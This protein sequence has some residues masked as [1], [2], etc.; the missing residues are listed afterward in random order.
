M[1]SGT[2]SWEMGMTAYQM[3]KVWGKF[4]PQFDAPFNYEVEE[5]IVKFGD[6]KSNRIFDQAQEPMEGLVNGLMHPDP[7][8][9]T[10]MFDL[11]NNKTFFETPGF[12]SPEVRELMKALATGDDAKIQQYSQ[13]VDNLKPKDDGERRAKMFNE[14]KG[15]V[16]TEAL[17]TTG[18]V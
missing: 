2:D 12:G 9:R 3:L 18:L 6:D 5:N 15:V 10:T 4:P 7:K 11:L 13:E 1:T 14:R 16:M 17:E 8:K